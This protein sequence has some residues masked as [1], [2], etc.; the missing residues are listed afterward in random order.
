MNEFVCF[1]DK[2][3]DAIAGDPL[4][5]YF[6]PIW[7]E[8]CPK[9]PFQS[10]LDVGCGNGLFSV[11]LKQK[12]GCMLTGVDGSAYALA[13]AQKA[14]FDET[15]LI[16]DFCSKPLPFPDEEFDM[17]LCKD[18]LEHL[19]DPEYLVS[20]MVR[21]L[22]PG[23][24]LL[25]H[26]PNHFSLYGRVRFLF[27]NNIDTWNYYPDSKRW[28]IPHVRFYTHQS[29]VELLGQYNCTPVRDFS[30]YFFSMPKQ[31]YLPS[32]IRI[33]KWLTR[34]APSQFAQGF[35]ILATKVL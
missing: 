22:K 24:H 30:Y 1:P 12:V 5:N 15:H 29:V 6:T 23:G 9:V 8:I 7:D 10:L 35:T 34:R 13:Q 32:K 11:A 25:V 21:V 3:T 14:G 18:V 19:L 16:Q 20:Q 17:I 4:N 28:N 26:V 31:Q 27:T 2:Y 33:A